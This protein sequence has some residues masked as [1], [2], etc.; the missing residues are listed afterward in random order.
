MNKN[1]R[2]SDR[3][4]AELRKEI[5][6]IISK[7]LKNPEVT[8]M[9][10]VLS[11]D[12]SKDLAHAKVY[13]SIYSKDVKKAEATFEAIK[14][15]AKKIR[16]ELARSVRARTVPELSFVLDGSMAYGDKMDKLFIEIDKRE[17]LS[18]TTANLADEKPSDNESD[19]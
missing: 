19:K 7:K 18:K 10:S 2:R 8:E 1:V 6:E 4:N 13:L 11:V 16:Y 12:T 14:S 5:Y 17:K 3:F 9:V 15:D